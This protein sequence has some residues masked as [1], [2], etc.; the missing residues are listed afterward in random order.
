MKPYFWQFL[1]KSWTDR[2]TEYENILLGLRN[3]NRYVFSV[4]GQS[5][6]TGQS[7][8]G[9]CLGSQKTL[10]T[11]QSGQ[12]NKVIISFGQSGQS[13]NSKKTFLL[14]TVLIQSFYFF[15]P[16]PPKHSVHLSKKISKAKIILHN[17]GF[18]FGQS[19]AKAKLKGGS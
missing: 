8:W 19:D 17:V 10:K 14:K 4:F 12:S 16:V 6:L 2:W 9:E 11:G 1:L 5:G 7:L 3:E 18:S 13:E 15:L